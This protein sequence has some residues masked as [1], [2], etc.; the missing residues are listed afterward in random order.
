ML[1]ANDQQLL[2]TKGISA[3]MIEAQTK[4]FEDGFPQ[5]RIHSVATVVP[6]DL[7]VLQPEKRALHFVFQN[8]ICA[9]IKASKQI[10]VTELQFVFEQFT[11]CYCRLAF[12]FRAHCALALPR[13]H[14]WHSSKF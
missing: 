2:K 12:H 14:T 9:R 4:R 11:S 8:H 3:E 1:T 5:L 6:K 13:V 10:K 7:N